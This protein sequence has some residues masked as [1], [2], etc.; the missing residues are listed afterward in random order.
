MERLQVLRAKYR[1]LQ[2]RLGGETPDFAE[3]VGAAAG[4]A[5]EG[6]SF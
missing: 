3:A 4:A 6:T 1:V 2:V 5:P